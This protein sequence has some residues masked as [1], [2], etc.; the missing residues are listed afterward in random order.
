MKTVKLR[1][2]ST[3]ALMLANPMAEAGSKNLT[4]SINN[5]P[6]DVVPSAVLSQASKVCFAHHHK[7]DSAYQYDWA[8]I[9]DKKRGAIINR[10]PKNEL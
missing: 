9:K 10:Y 2:T 4:Y 1:I 5:V 8:E 6:D 3:G 7:D